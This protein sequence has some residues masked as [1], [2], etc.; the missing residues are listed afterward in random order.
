M[1]SFL[2]CSIAAKLSWESFV[3][4]ILLLTTIGFFVTSVITFYQIYLTLKG[5]INVN[6]YKQNGLNTD[7]NIF[8]GTIATKTFDIFESEVNSE[9]EV[10]YLNDLNSQIFVAANIATEKFK[11]YNK[12]LFWMFVSLGV[13]LFHIV[14]K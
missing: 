2:S 11:H 8:F 5:R 14:F 13:F 3:N 9:D 4:F 1:I 7:S 10:K 12:S 6:I